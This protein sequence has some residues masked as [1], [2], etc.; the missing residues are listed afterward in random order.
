MKIHILTGW[1]NCGGST[2][3]FINLTNLLNANKIDCTLYGPHN[4]HLNKCKSRNL[5]S[6]NKDLCEED[7]VIV[8]FL[9]LQENIQCKKLIF[10]SHEQHIFPI[11][12]KIDYRKFDLIHYVSNHQKQFHNVLWPHVIIPNILDDLQIGN[13]PSEKIGGIIGS[14]DRNKLT[15]ISID[16]A[17]S[18]GCRLVKMFG[19]VTDKEYFYRYVKPKIEEYFPR[20]TLCDFCDDKQIM[21]NQITD[22][23]QDS[24]NESWGYI[25]AECKKTGTNFHGNGSVQS[26]IEVLGNREILTRWLRAFRM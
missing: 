15:H 22:V 21:Y 24:Q 4:W 11:K 10:S 18:D 14:I 6:F 7:I 16:R 13:K 1:S 8:H 12:E 5:T 19:I 17:M 20:V 26:D 2:V 9:K 3:A 25:A 23:Y